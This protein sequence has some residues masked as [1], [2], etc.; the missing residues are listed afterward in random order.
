MCHIGTASQELLG[1]LHVQLV[2]TDHACFSA[3][4]LMHAGVACAALAVVFQVCEQM[5][6]FKFL[7]LLVVCLRAGACGINSGE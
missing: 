1:L 6:G 2:R 3:Q 5:A 4:A 7:A